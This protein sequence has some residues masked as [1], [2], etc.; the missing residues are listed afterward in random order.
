MLHGAALIKKEMLFAY[1]IIW[2]MASG[3]PVLTVREKR[4]IYEY[5]L[6]MT[7]IKIYFPL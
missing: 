2:F 4:K 1:S 7:R 5:F 3:A 6:K